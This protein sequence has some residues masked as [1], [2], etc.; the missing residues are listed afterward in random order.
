VISTSLL[1]WWLG[2][3][4]GSTAPVV[5]GSLSGVAI[6]FYRLLAASK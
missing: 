5:V 4:L 1:G 3:R 6:A 2:R